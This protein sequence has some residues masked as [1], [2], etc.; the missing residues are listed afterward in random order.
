MS[1]TSTT[2]IRFFAILTVELAYYFRE[3]SRNFLEGPQFLAE[4]F[5]PSFE[6]L[7]PLKNILRKLAKKLKN[8]RHWCKYIVVSVV[9]ISAFPEEVEVL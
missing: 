4:Y 2:V 5:D 1:T 7:K 3:W 8:V 6:N 9:L